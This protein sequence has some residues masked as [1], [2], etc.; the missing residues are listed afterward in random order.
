MSIVQ[1]HSELTSIPNPRKLSQC[2]KQSHLKNER[3]KL[4]DMIDLFYDKA[5]S[6]IDKALSKDN[7]RAILIC[8]ELL[9]ELTM[10]PKQ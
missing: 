9:N 8:K 7:K 4:S 5:K 1:L 6:R 2:G 3:D 10:Y